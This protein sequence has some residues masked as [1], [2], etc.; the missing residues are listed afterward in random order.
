[1][2][3]YLDTS[4]SFLYSAIYNDGKI[5]D[6]INLN[7]SK[8]LSSRALSLVN[9]MLKKNNLYFND[10]KKIIVVNGPGSFT[11]VRVGLTI[12]KVLAWSVKIPIITVSSLEAMALSSNLDEGYVVPMIDARRNYYYS[13]IFDIKNKCFILKEQYVNLD[14]LIAS[15]STIS[16][17]ITIISNDE[18]KADYNIIKYEPNF[19]KIV[20]YAKDKEPTPVHLVDANYLKQTEAEEKRNDNWT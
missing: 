7:L 10:L 1:M 12:A 19:L 14:V 15:F 16:E 20:E 17:L 4:S 5:I 2:I 9:E 8:D 11:G 13:G 18:V 3:L 6:S